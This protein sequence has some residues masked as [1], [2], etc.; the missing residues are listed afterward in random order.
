MSPA[1][2]AGGRDEQVARVILIEGSVNVLA[3]G[4]KL[5][6]GLATWSLAVVADALHSL[7][8]VANNGVAWF[9]LRASSRPPDREHP[10]G[11]RKFETVAVFV[12]A[13]LLTILAFEL[14]RHAA[15]GETWPTRHEGW[16]LVVMGVV[17]C[18][19]TGLATWQARWARRLDSPILRAD[20]SHTF[21]DVLT[22]LV[23]V[24][25]WQTAA[26][27]W[28]WIDRLCAAGVG[29]LI[30]NLAFGLFRRALPVLL[31]GAALDP[32]EITKTVQGVDG[33]RSV[34]NVR[35]RSDGTQAAVDLVVRVD[36]ELSTAASHEI[37]DRVERALGSA[38][39]VSDVT[40]HV[41]PADRTS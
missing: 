5:F 32:E 4:L 30:L 15:L 12:L 41:E 28:P 37:A 24:A 1:V 10:Y 11:H 9:V 7:T 3:L 23:V 26:R 6:V 21:A 14:I 16:G 22:T 17:L 35:S 29:L 39:A 20:A 25:G 19:N 27:G 8:D 33:V 34:G 40:V 31:D 2:R 13:G 36:P 38:Y 18:L